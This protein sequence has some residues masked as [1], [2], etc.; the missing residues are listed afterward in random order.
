LY[1]KRVN[2]YV[3]AVSGTLSY[4][5]CIVRPVRHACIDR[6]EEIRAG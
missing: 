1:A 3:I 5:A 6:E 2:A 4:L